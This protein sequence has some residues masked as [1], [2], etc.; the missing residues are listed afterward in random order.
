M[1]TWLFSSSVFTWNESVSSVCSS[2][3][4]ISARFIMIKFLN[5]IVILF[6]HFCCLPWEIE[7]HHGSM[8]WNFIPGLKS[9]YKQPLWWSCFAK[10]VNH[11][12]KRLHLGCL[13]GF[14]MCLCCVHDNYLFVK[15]LIQPFSWFQW[16]FKASSFST[17]SIFHETHTLA[18]QLATKS[19]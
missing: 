9:W 17:F 5:I 7:S 18:L 14:W 19:Y 13:T 11:L 2:R 12:C 8:S 16:W 4:W 1:I 15:F 3:G 6:L 10:M